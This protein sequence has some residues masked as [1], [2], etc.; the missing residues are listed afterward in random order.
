MQPFQQKKWLVEQFEPLKDK[1]I[2]GA[3]Q[4]NHEY[5]TTIETGECPLYDVMNKLDIEDLYRQNMAFLKVNLGKKNA[6]KTVEL[7]NSSWTWS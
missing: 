4:G 6:K 3:N 5:R 2:L 7:Y 1:K